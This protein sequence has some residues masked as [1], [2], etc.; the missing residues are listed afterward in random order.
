MSLYLEF[1]K[2]KLYEFLRLQMKTVLTRYFYFLGGEGGV[3]NVLPDLDISNSSL[4]V[5]RSAGG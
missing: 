3:H 2:K 5:G 1:V 4:S